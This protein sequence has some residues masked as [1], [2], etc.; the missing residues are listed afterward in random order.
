MWRVTALRT[1]PTAAL[2]RLSPEAQASGLTA[3]RRIKRQRRRAAERLGIQRYSR[4]GLFDLDR[5]LQAYLPAIGTFVEAGANDGFRQSNTYYLERWLG[6]NGLLVEPVP[7]LAEQAR[8]ERKAPIVCAALVSPDF[9]ESSIT[10]QAK[11]LCSSVDMT[12][13]GREIGVRSREILVQARQFSD[14]LDDAGI[15]DGSFSSK[16]IAIATRLKRRWAEATYKWR[17]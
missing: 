11:G 3:W 16:S 5:Q 17:N 4:P 8:R 7:S 13:D 1:V 15:S 14:V 12:R 9:S 6:W 10:I 2:K